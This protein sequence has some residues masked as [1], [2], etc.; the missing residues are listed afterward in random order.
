MGAEFRGNIRE[1]QRFQAAA[2]GGGVIS[3]QLDLIPGTYSRPF[4]TPVPRVPWQ[5]KCHLSDKTINT[6]CRAVP[7]RAELAPASYDLAV[8]KRRRQP[9]AFILPCPLKEPRP[10]VRDLGAEL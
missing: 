6:R 1:A 5:G 3:G 4:P 9:G 2:R 10:A 8:L 7:V